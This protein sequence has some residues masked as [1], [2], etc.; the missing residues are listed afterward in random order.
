MPYHYG[1]M[2]AR[3]MKH[4]RKDSLLLAFVMALGLSVPAM[5]AGVAARLGFVKL[6][7]EYVKPEMADGAD[8]AFED[9]ADLS[10]EDTSASVATFSPD[11][12][13]TRADL[14]QIRPI[15]RALPQAPGTALPSP[16][17]DLLNREQALLIAVRMVEDLGK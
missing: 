13:M 9:C 16:P 14:E 8:L 3:N 6:L 15:S 11:G 2:E 17:A 10:D 7:A 12:A 1:R 4:R 5:A